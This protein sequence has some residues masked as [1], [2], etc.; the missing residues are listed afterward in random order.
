MDI[1]RPLPHAVLPDSAS[2]RCEEGPAMRASQRSAQQPG[3]LQPPSPATP[4]SALP[5]MQPSAPR[6]GVARGRAR[7]VLF[8]AVLLLAAAAQPAACKTAAGD[9]NAVEA[10]AT[11]A[12]PTGVSCYSPS[13]RAWL[14]L[15]PWCGVGMDVFRWRCHAVALQDP[16]PNASVTDAAHPHVHL[17]QMCCST[18]GRPHSRRPANYVWVFTRCLKQSRTVLASTQLRW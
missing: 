15:C 3:R 10:A 13:A 7:A 17:V 12:A 4:R 16:G 8:V 2:A 14:G 5:P 11:D 9:A 6:R 18:A 1:T